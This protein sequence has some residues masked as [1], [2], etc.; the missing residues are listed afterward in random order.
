MGG[1]KTPDLYRCVV[2]LAPV[3]DLIWKIRD[4]TQDYGR[5]SRTTA[6]NERTLGT[7]K[8]DKERLQA[9][10]P[11]NLADNFKAPVLLIHGKDDTVVKIRQSRKMEKA[12]K[13]AGKSV[14]FVQLKG[15]DHWLSLGETRIATLQAMSSFVDRHIGDQATVETVAA[16]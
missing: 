1:A 11:V 12:L 14:E 5:N 4:Q 15:E 2:A 10:S 9:T 6:Y 13:K 3:T 7:L 8:D 16:E